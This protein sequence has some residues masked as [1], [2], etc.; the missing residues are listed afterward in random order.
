MKVKGQSAVVPFGV[1]VWNEI[2]TGGVEVPIPA[3]AIGIVSE[4]EDL[5]TL[6]AGGIQDNDPFAKQEEETDDLGNV[7]ALNWKKG[8]LATNLV[9]TPRF[10]VSVPAILDNCVATLRIRFA[11]ANWCETNKNEAND[12]NNNRADWWFTGPAKTGST[13]FVD[14]DLV[15]DT[16]WTT[17]TVNNPG[18]PELPECTGETREVSVQPT[19]ADIDTYLPYR[20]FTKNPG[21]Y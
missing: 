15:Q 1:A 9:G 3:G 17:L 14:P 20:P 6:N 2:Q 16:F 13:Q 10:R 21:P 12:G 11:V 19:G 5:I 7:R 18:N 4:D 8:A